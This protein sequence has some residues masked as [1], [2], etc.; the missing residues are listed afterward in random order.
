MGLGRLRLVPPAATSCLQLGSTFPGEHLG[1][2]PAA[3]MQQ[4]LLTWVKPH[5]EPSSALWHVS[6]LE[7][8]SP[9]DGW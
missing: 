8:R 9:A 6:A 2:T 4:T 1:F 3:A 7:L 5:R